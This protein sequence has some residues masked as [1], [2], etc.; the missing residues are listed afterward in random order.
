[1]AKPIPGAVG[2]GNAQHL[3]QN[4]F[5]GNKSNTFDT[6]LPVSASTGVVADIS[7]AA[8][9]LSVTGAVPFN[10]SASKS[11][12]FIEEMTKV[13]DTVVNPGGWLPV[14][15]L[16]STSNRKIVV[17]KDDLTLPE[18]GAGILIVTG[19]LTLSENFS[20]DCVMVVAMV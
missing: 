9:S 19:N 5:S 16:G 18:G 12:K 20:Y 7:T 17:V 4:S 11:R 6:N 2:A 13:A 15:A 8:P 3:W 10:N 1:M 14:G